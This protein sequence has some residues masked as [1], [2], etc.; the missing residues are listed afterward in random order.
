[1]CWI[2]PA[3]PH[4]AE[5]TLKQWDLGLRMGASTRNEY[6]VRVL[7]LQ[8]LPGLDVPLEP[9]GFLPANDDDNNNDQNKPEKRLNGQRRIT[10]TA[11]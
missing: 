11:N 10:I 8:P 2:E 4:D 5:N 9:A 1:M 7:N 6:R 3:Q